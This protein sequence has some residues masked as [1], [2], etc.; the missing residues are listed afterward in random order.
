MLKYPVTTFR[1][2]RN[3]S[4]IGR[5]YNERGLP[6]FTPKTAPQRVV[7]VFVTVIVWPNFPA[8]HLL[9]FFAIFCHF[10]PFFAIFAIFCHLLHVT[11]GKLSTHDAQSMKSDLS[12]KLV[13]SDLGMGTFRHELMRSEWPF[14]RWSIECLLYFEGFIIFSPQ[15]VHIKLDSPQAAR[16]SISFR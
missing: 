15:L 7:I 6:S 3:Q 13:I 5:S 1:S 8:K 9:S 4:C 12:T 11:E 2:C 16:L 10:L 14:E